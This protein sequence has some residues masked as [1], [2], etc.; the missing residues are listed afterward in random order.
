[1]KIND[2]VATG[3]R[4][5]E[6]SE[7]S[8]HGGQTRLQRQFKQTPDTTTQP[9]NGAGRLSHDQKGFERRLRLIA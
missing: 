7:L 4:L 1:V 3:R 6:A 8:L 9:T 2:F 5:I